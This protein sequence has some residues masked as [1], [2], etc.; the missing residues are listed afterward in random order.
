MGIIFVVSTVV[1]AIFSGLMCR[2]A[3][4]IIKNAAAMKE[5]E[6]INLKLARWRSDNCFLCLIYCSEVHHIPQ[7]Y[8]QV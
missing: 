4:A 3:K 5:L 2:N 7:C 8:I 1:I 6:K